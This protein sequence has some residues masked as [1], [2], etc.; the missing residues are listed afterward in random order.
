MHQAGILGEINAFELQLLQTFLAFSSPSLTAADA[1]HPR[2]FDDRHRRKR[3]IL[4]TGSR[5]H[6]LD[7]LVIVDQDNVVNAMGFGGTCESRK[8]MRSW[9]SS[10]S[11]ST[12][13]CPILT[14]CFELTFC[15]KL[16]FCFELTF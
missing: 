12:T 10:S 11:T 2:D 3:P 13:N 6:R 8:D 15:F 4:K 7:N 1:T 9:S 14:L 5:R 16:T